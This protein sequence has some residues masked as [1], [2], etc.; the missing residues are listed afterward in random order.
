MHRGR[1]ELF[2][3]IGKPVASEG[4]PRGPDAGPDF[5]LDQGGDTPLPS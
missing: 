5:H 2:Q 1:R 3:E 4:L